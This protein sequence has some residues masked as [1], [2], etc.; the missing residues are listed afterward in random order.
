VYTQCGPAGSSFL[1]D[2]AGRAGAPRAL[3]EQ[4]FI[5]AN[6]AMVAAAVL[7][8]PEPARQ[9]RRAAGILLENVELD[10]TPAQ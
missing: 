8:S 7:N 10:A 9:A 6:G 4:L 5:L 3:G 2:L 1:A